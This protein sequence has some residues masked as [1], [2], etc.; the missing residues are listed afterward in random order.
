MDQHLC[1]GG[2]CREAYSPRPAH[3]Q[4]HRLV[5]SLSIGTGNI[6]RREF[7]DGGEIFAMLAKP[8]L[9]TVRC[10]RRVQKSAASEKPA[11]SVFDARHREAEDTT[12][13]FFLSG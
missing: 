6:S 11:K 10:S 9:V 7:A 5:Y 2:F 3:T 12:P 13:E 8:R 4:L 1:C